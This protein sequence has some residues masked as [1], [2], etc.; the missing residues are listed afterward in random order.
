MEE[1]IYGLILVLILL[2]FF[3]PICRELIIICWDN[4]KSIK[5]W[6]FEKKLTGILVVINTI[7]AF[8]KKESPFQVF[9]FS[10]LWILVINVIFDS[11]LKNLNWD[12]QK[13]KIDEERFSNQ[14]LFQKQRIKFVVLVIIFSIEF[15]TQLSYNH[16]IVN[17][18]K[19]ILPNNNQFD[20]YQ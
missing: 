15:L 8:F 13:V 5:D 3:F 11:Y 19:W 4:R 16:S 12:Y 2:I 14:I 1:L 6:S 18:I 7:S 10:L 20:D 9:L 17:L